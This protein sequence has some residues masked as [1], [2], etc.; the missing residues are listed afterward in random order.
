M[1]IIGTI[2]LHSYLSAQ[3][4]SSDL[5]DYIDP[6]FRE[7]EKKHTHL[8]KKKVE[9]TRDYRRNAIKHYRIQK[10]QANVTSWRNTHDIVHVIYTRFMQRQPN[11]VE[12]G[13][14]R[15][16]L[17]ERFCL[18]TI[19]EQTNQQFL[20]IIRTDPDLHPT[21]KE[22]LLKVI[23][24]VPNV[25][26]VGSNEIRKGSINGGFRSQSAISDITPKS[27]FYGDIDLIRSFH[28]ATKGRTLLETNLDADDGL[29]LTF[30]E[31]AQNTTATK[32]Q[33]VKEQ[34]GWMNLCVGRHLEWQYFSPWD[35]NTEKGS[36][37]LGSTHVCI[38][39]G[40]SWATQTQARPHFTEA[41]HLIKKN[42]TAC[43][44]SSESFLGCWEEIHV[45]TEADVMAIRARTPTS[46]GMSRVVFEDSE[47]KQEEK[48]T[49]ASSWS[50]LESSFA[51]TQADVMEARKYLTDHL[52]ELTEE[53][54]EGQCTKDHSCS[55]NI[56][57]KLKSLIFKKDSLWKNK[58]ELVHVIQTSLET[59]LSVDVWRD[60]SLNSLEAQST[61]EF[62]WIVRVKDFS[63]NNVLQELLESVSKSPINLLLVKSDH[64]PR[65]DFRDAQAI[66]DISK[67]TL[68]HGDIA[69]LNDYHRQAQNLTLLETSLE[70]N[71]A[72]NKTF[73]SDI[74]SST[75]D[76]LKS[77]QL[78]DEDTWYYRCVSEYIEWSYFSLKVDDHNNTNGFL[79]AVSPHG[80]SC[81][82]YPAS[83]RISLPGAK[84]QQGHI[85]PKECLNLGMLTIR[86]G[87][88]TSMEADEIQSARALLPKLT[89]KPPTF[90]LTPIELERLE[91]QDSSLR[92][93]L[94]DSFN[95]YPKS[96]EAMRT[97]IKESHDQETRKW[98]NTH[99]VVH[100]IHTVI[101]EPS[102]FEV[103]RKFS[104]AM[105]SQTTDKFL[106]LVRVGSDSSLIENVLNLVR[107]TPLN[108]VVVKAD[109]GSVPSFRSKDDTARITPE[110]ILY[111]DSGV[112]E[113]FK[114]RAQNYP[115]LETFLDPTEA[116]R[117][118]FAEDV[119]KS[120]SIQIEKNRIR[121]GLD[122]WYFR[123]V[124]KYVEWN[125]KAPRRKETNSVGGLSVL[126][127]AVSQ[128][129]KSPATT[130][131]SLRGAEIPA[132]PQ[133]ISSDECKEGELGKGCYERIAT[134]Q[135]LAARANL[136]G[137]VKDVVKV[138]AIER[139]HTD[140]IST[141]GADFG[142]YPISLHLMQREIEAK[143]VGEGARKSHDLVHVVYSRFMQGQPTLLHMG[144]ARMKLFQTFCL[145][146][147]RA[148]TNQNFLWI[149]RTDPDLHSTLRDELVKSLDGMSNVVVV[150]SN[151]NQEGNYNGGFRGPD[152]ID[153]FVEAPIFY[154]DLQLIRSYH[155]KAKTRTLLETNLD[156]DDGVTL[157]FIES[158]QA[159]TMKR[160][161]RDHSKIGWLN[162]CIGRHLEWHF[163][164][165]WSKHSDQGCLL[166][167]LTRSCVKSGMSW[168]TQPNSS[169]KFVL[170]SNSVKL[171]T[172]SCSFNR[173]VDNYLYEGCWE[174][175]PQ[176]NPESDV[177]AIRAMTPSSKGLARGEVNSFDWNIRS[178]LFD[179]KAW[180][181]LD[182]YFGFSP[183]NVIQARNYILE[184]LQEVVEDNQMS[185][186]RAEKTCVGKWENNHR[187]VHVV[188]TSIQ[189]ENTA[190]LL[191]RICMSSL[192]RQTNSQYLWIIRVK[193][194]V[195][196]R[197]ILS[198]LNPI[199]KAHLNVLIVKSDH[200]DS[201]RRDFRTRLGIAD[202]S[203]VTLLYGDMTVL[204]DYH[205]ASQDHPLLET[206]LGP[207][208]GLTRSFIEDLQSSVASKIE[209]E[210]I[211]TGESGWYYHCVSQYFERSF[212]TPSGEVSDSGFSM[213]IGHDDGD[214]IERPG[215]TR[216]SLP[217]SVI[218]ESIEASKARG[219]ALQGIE[220]G[221]FFSMESEEPLSL[222]MLLP[223]TPS[224]PRNFSADEVKALE[225]KQKRWTMTFRLVYSVFLP[226]LESMREII[227]ENER[228]TVHVVHTWLKE[229]AVENI[230]LWRS[231]CTNSIV[232]QTTKNFLWIIRVD[233]DG[234]LSLR[235][236]PLWNVLFPLIFY[237]KVPANVLVVTSSHTPMLDFR[238]N[239]AISDITNKTLV[240]GQMETLQD[241]HM[242]AKGRTVLETYLQPSDGIINT[243]SA[244]LQN[245]TEIWLKENN[246]QSGHGPNAWYY[247]CSPG[248]IEWNYH[249]PRGEE[250]KNGFVK[251]TNVEMSK[252]MDSPALTRI[253]LPGAEVTDDK[254]P[255]EVRECS[256]KAE[257]MEK[258]CFVSYG[259]N[260]DYMRGIHPQS[261]DSPILPDLEKSKVDDLEKEDKRLQSLLPA[262]FG[263]LPFE[264][265]IMKKKIEDQ[266]CGGGH[267][268]SSK[269][270]SKDGVVHIVYT[271]LQ[272]MAE[273]DLYRN[274]CF[275]SLETQIT[276]KF[277]FILR[278]GPDAKLIKEVLKPIQ[279]T[280]L[281]IIVVQSNYTS[282]I[283]F[284]NPEAI[285]DIKNTTIKHGELK[286]LEHFHQQAQSR[287]LIE[288]FLKPE[289]A[290]TNTFVSDLQNI[291]AMHY[292]ENPMEDKQQAWHYKCF[293][294][295]IEWNYFNPYG[296]EADL[297]FLRRVDSHNGKCIDGLATTR[298][299]LPGAKISGD[300]LSSLSPECS[301]GK[302]E[303]GCVSPMVAK[304]E[305]LRA[306][307][308]DSLDKPAVLEISQSQFNELEKMD[309]SLW[310][311]IKK[312]FSIYPIA[313]KKM[314][315][316]IRK[317]K[318]LEKTLKW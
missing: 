220:N 224:K 250:K 122:S 293:S 153:E 248:Y 307:V 44:R 28:S 145:P 100:V 199:S 18:T 71:E 123:C 163:N 127:P 227:E 140:I 235:S 34:N 81:M 277:L 68:L 107:R 102:T 121:P 276:N 144:K 239:E 267:L 92:G 103:W 119:Q 80:S 142:I 240:L 13:L 246:L 101:L 226:T 12:L 51:I 291:T 55:E 69:M 209:E 273:F 43:D 289:D 244:D 162:L 269:Y 195:D 245:S 179:K 185:K 147:L 132:D 314:R 190:N 151:L 310:G 21:L 114:L 219:C 196:Y 318:D 302:L 208:E 27:L 173:T 63:D 292:A 259:R 115:L 98:D 255:S 130:M 216:V 317:R 270:D 137:S 16:E 10:Q 262:S 167:G 36:L 309:K 274:F 52:Q 128:C 146:T 290:V 207:T 313:L 260:E 285:D 161:E 160:F 230:N 45:D 295:Y 117:N 228:Q 299:S 288:T 29:A 136:P 169:P 129:L 88:Y 264:A 164:A 120:T 266:H 41:H 4:K 62:L 258:G 157:T 210:S 75:V 214:C 211:N 32:F 141:I 47:W 109:S 125:Y 30:V 64:V 84:I 297:G 287:P 131:V 156:T 286:V 202:I 2:V 166:S 49:D 91:E 175:V 256:S 26:L 252:C 205:K 35:K 108:V 213:V 116:L 301:S 241:F 19:T 56:K 187:L 61:Y 236:G 1:G 3:M 203:D 282:T 186:C 95:V 233:F 42:T 82:K 193:D 249:T 65:T 172:P 15:L 281:N 46:T 22:G 218:P 37:H 105:E 254:V 234:D 76:Q 31:K 24:G 60:F 159:K 303:S 154:G 133:K 306:F 231:I 271:S 9:S 263:F 110:M 134:E 96:V 247:K 57:K 215:T 194:F 72:L 200:D 112:L 206:F 311:S 280:P 225:A 237:F 171:E 39:P 5:E 238:T 20:W 221:C 308:P 283:D 104:F 192:A 113:Y 294:K 8:R 66:T 25:A 176:I 94:R 135:V 223:Y 6:S 184:N 251:L 111:G 229:P 23:D 279:K 188:H 67:E 73:V 181:L 197:L 204:H 182:P 58:H 284:R 48:E 89:E 305:A 152:G 33:N 253:S 106:W 183:E 272:D 180:T 126:T 53:N 87:C 78:Q 201:H 177:M 165:P 178:L 138:T 97:H 74:Q 38:T 212:Y 90:E 217:G 191:H 257:E 149:I 85:T 174:E 198:I 268:C 189:D 242:A 304:H 158:A 86:N 243:F 139:N 168:A 275:T 298:I 124:P 40:L 316:S 77:S 99:G 143:I 59:P 261:L 54:L 315:Q 265:E 148:Q 170:E 93:I 11:L 150:G 312:D 232:A 278:V 83:T 7:T 155:D 300:I 17:F 222:R 79:R 70:P 118:T 14:A 50:M 296:R